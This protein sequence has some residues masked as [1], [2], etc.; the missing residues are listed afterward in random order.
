MVAAGCLLLVILPILGLL[1]GSWIG[2]GQA[3][4]WCALAGF[5]IAAALCGVAGYALVQAGRRR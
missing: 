2:G 4:L 1:V 5:L 3:A